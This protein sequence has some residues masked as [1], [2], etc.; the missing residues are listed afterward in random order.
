MANQC[1]PLFRF[2]AG[3]QESAWRKS[4]FNILKCC[5]QIFLLCCFLAVCQKSTFCVLLS[6]FH[7]TAKP[8]AGESACEETFSAAR[9]TITACGK[10][11]EPNQVP[12][13]S[14]KPPTE[15]AKGSQH[16]DHP[17]FCDTTWDKKT[18]LSREDNKEDLGLQLLYLNVPDSPGHPW[19]SSK[20]WDSESPSCAC[21][22]Q[23]WEVQVSNP[24]SNGRLLPKVCSASWAL[25]FKEEKGKCLKGTSAKPIFTFQSKVTDSWEM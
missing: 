3:T 15:R 12:A 9:T 21:S 6:Q 4:S 16:P 7:Y 1:F 17:S 11:V 8:A 10:E 18:L 22:G 20:A 24:S 13:H 5:F 2:G 14:P 23:H 19:L 25:T